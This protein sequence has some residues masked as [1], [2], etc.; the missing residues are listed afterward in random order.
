MIYIIYYKEFLFSLAER[1][2]ST[3]LNMKSYIGWD[4]YGKCE[5]E[6]RRLTRSLGIR[7]ID[8]SSFS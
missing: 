3:L 6:I 7:L 5:S 1:A 2:K 8:S 4:A